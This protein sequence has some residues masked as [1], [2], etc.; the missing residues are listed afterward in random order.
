M[1]L[2]EGAIKKSTCI[3]PKVTLWVWRTDTNIVFFH[4]NPSLLKRGELPTF[5]LPQTVDLN[6]RGA[7]QEDGQVVMF[8]QAGMLR[9]TSLHNG[10]RPNWQTCCCTVATG[11]T[12]KRTVHDGLTLPQGNDHLV[13]DPGKIY[14]SARQFRPVV[15][16][17][18]H[19]KVV[20]IHVNNVARNEFMDQF[21]QSGLTAT[22]ASVDGDD[23]RSSGLRQLCDPQ[24]NW[25]V[26][27]VLCPQQAVVR[28]ICFAISVG[29]VDSRAALVSV[30]GQPVCHA[31]YVQGIQTG[32]IFCKSGRGARNFLSG[33]DTELC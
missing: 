9:V 7:G 22:A 13:E 17:V 33:Q 10:Q 2:T 28:M 15:G 16:S 14:I 1:R 30:F 12:V 32:K 8:C 19:G 21:R 20:I 3:H 24:E 18:R 31:R 25:E 11:G 23:R 5:S 26:S 6:I 4:W 29:M 27:G